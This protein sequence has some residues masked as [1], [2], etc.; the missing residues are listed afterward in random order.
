VTSFQAA[1]ARFG[2]MP[3][4]SIIIPCYNSQQWVGEAIESALS[5]EDVN[6]EVIVV[7]DGSTDDSLSIVRR[8]S[9][10]IRICSGPNRGACAARNIGVSMARGRY[11]QFLD[12]DDLLHSKKIKRSLEVFDGR[13]DRLVFSLHDV[14]SLSPGITAVQWNRRDDCSDAIAFMLR[15]D[16]PTPA[17][18]HL[19]AIIE[20]IGGFRAGLP[21]A[22]DRDFHVRMA[23]AGVKF[24]LIPE[25][26]HTIRRRSGSIG[27]SDD[28]RVHRYRGKIAIETHERLQS[29]G[30]LTESLA[31]DCAAMLC[32]AAR[33]MAMRDPVTAKRY[34]QYA[35]DM[36]PSGGKH[37]VYSRATRSLLPIFGF[38]GTERLVH[39]AREIR[40][41]FFAKQPLS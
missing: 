30:R 33:G 35:V 2:C 40:R 20:G 1:V 12:S 37:V 28:A 15:G 31:V 17:P 32:H 36:H 11:I 7:D 25:P 18:L 8:Y 5:Q 22:Q 27:T 39:M 26:L 34:A 3:T 19:K 4:A 24:E 10:A 23:L 14:T 29:E 9:D 16:L 21:C 41:A 6:V 13:H 38:N